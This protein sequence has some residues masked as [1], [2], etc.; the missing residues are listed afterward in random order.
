LENANATILFHRKKAIPVHGRN[1]FFLVIKKAAF[2]QKRKAALITAQLSM[3][4]K[5]A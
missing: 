3:F 2:L 4:R 1:P 5:K